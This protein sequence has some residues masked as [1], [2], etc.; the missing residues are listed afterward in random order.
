[1]KL[2]LSSKI[3]STPHR[4]DFFWPGSEALEKMYRDKYDN[5]Q[6]FHEGLAAV[7]SNGKWGFID[8]LGRIA[9]PLMYDEVGE[10][11]YQS[12]APVKLNGKLFLINKEGE[13]VVPIKN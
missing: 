4:A 8:P 5:M 6:P 3:Q 7:L 9:I 13:E 10:G 12:L 11:F 2:K 1:M